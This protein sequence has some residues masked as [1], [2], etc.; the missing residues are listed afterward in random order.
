[1]R[2]D[3]QG[4]VNNL[5]WSVLWFDGRSVFL[6]RGELAIQLGEQNPDSITLC[7]WGGS[8]GRRTPLVTDLPANEQP[9]HIIVL[10]TESAGE[11]FAVYFQYSVQ[12]L[13]SFDIAMKEYVTLPMKECVY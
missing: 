12:Q 2:A 1:V 13:L 4:H 10:A 5:V 6:L 9:M 3:D 8:E 11:N 7:V